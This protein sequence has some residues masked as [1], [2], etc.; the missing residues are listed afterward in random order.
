MWQLAVSLTHMLKYGSANVR[1]MSLNFGKFH[2]SFSLQ[3]KSASVTSHVNTHSHTHTQHMW[4]LQIVPLLIYLL[5]TNL[6]FSSTVF[7]QPIP[8][9]P[10]ST[11]VRLLTYVVVC[12]ATPTARPPAHHLRQLFLFAQQLKISIS[13]AKIKKKKENVP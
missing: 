9:I 6:S 7:L 10:R 12:I 8:P 13:R 11:C 5:D 4:C 2:L 1:K 3:K